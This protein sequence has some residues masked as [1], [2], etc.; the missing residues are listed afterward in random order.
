MNHKDL[1]LFIWSLRIKQGFTLIELVMVIVIIGILS[2][3]AIPQFIDLRG[4]A[5]QAAVNGVA[6]ALGSASAINYAA[7]VAGSPN[8]IAVDNCTDIAGALAGGA[9]P[10]AEYAIADQAIASGATATCT[11]TLT[12]AG[13]GRQ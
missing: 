8:A 2:A 7:S 11:V 6:G 4:E 5:R 3:I 13:G 10:S 1:V 9:L 12:P